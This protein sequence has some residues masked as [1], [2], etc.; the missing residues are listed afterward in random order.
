MSAGG[1][2]QRDIESALAKALGQFVISKSA[3]SDLTDRLSHEYEAF[4]SRDRSGFDI[5]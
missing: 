5:A 3:G 2:A 4:R 1:M